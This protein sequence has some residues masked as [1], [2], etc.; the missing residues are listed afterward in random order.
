[1]NG[2]SHIPLPKFIADKKAVINMKNEDDQCLKWCV[3]RALNP[4]EKNAERVTKDLRR[5]VT[6]LNWGGVRFPVQ[7]SDIPRVERLNHLK[8][9][10]F[11]TEGKQFYPLRI[12][13]AETGFQI[14]LL[15]SNGEKKHFYLIKDKSRLLRSQVT[16][17]E[18]LII[19]CDSCLNHFSSEE[20]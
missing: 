1:L 6:E 19:F 18:E 11:G 9:N 3:T 2:S 13:R 14:D 16:K 5:Q 10:V 8:I 15:I 12:S 20:G 17:H 7:L 4:V